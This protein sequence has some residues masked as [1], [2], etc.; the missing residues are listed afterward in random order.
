MSRTMSAPARIG[1]PPPPTTLRK[2]A[3]PTTKVDHRRLRGRMATDRDAL[4][5]TELEAR[6]RGRAS[7]WALIAGVVLALAASGGSP[8][9]AQLPSWLPERRPNIIVF[10]A[11]D[12]GAHELG[13]YGNQE[14][15]TPNLDRLAAT[16]T[17]FRTAYATPVCAPSR[18]MILTGRY[19]F[20]TG[21]YNNTT[22]RGGSDDVVQTRTKLGRHELSFANVLRGAGYSTGITGKWQLGW[23]RGRLLARCGFDE[24]LI[25]APPSYRPAGEP[26][27]GMWETEDKP[28]RYWH[29]SILENRKA[30]ATRPDDYGPDLFCD[31]LIDF[32]ERDR[33]E[34]FL[35][36]YSM[37]LPHKPWVSTPATPSAERDK[38]D[39]RR[40]RKKE[41]IEYMDAIVGRVVAALDASGKRED[42]ILFFTSDNGSN[43]VGKR[44]PTEMG[45]RVPLIVNGPGRV[46]EGHVSGELVDFSDVLPTLAELAGTT[47]PQDREIDGVSFASTLRGEPGPR[48]EW[49][50]SFVADYRILRDERW[51]LEHHSPRDPGRFFDCGDSRD[52]S[53][54]VDVTDSTDPEVLAARAR[55]ARILEELPAPVIQDG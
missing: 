21:V 53:G 8:L 49:A 45:V 27:L 12:L 15:D 22:Y 30:V 32:I 20:R 55:F 25:W 13:C 23:R 17:R 33:D 7:S 36:Y 19:G 50:F 37:A 10:L 43:V 11:D 54:Y 6:S 41:K 48:R 24:H 18:M 31:W 44:K 38:F 39:H 4:A 51:L 1:V 46:L 52:G 47:A 28:S 3:P 34:P 40:P 35:L 9:N 26:H 42:T 29:P 5:G 16:G 14:H 2:N